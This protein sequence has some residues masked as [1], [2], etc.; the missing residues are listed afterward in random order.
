MR[1]DELEGVEQLA[2]G[3]LLQVLVVRYNLHHAVPN[4][5]RDEVSSKRD[6]LQRKT[7]VR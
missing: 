3:V 5:V 7:W 2:R 6:E 4:V 1:R